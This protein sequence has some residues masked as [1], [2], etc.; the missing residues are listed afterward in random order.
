MKQLIVITL[1][2]V[3]SCAFSDSGGIAVLNP[4]FE[5]DT[6]SDRVPDNWEL[7]IGGNAKGKVELDSDQYHSG[8]KSVRISNASGSAPFVYTAIKS[9]QIAVQPSTTYVARFFAKATDA[10]KVSVHIRCEGAGNRIMYIEEGDYDWKEFR[11]QFT[12]AERTQLMRIFFVSEDVTG[13]LWIDDVSIELADVQ[14]ANL[15]EKHYPKDFPGV[16][17]RSRGPL[18]EHLTVF[19][20]RRQANDDAMEMALAALQGLVNR[21]SP[22]LYMINQTN[23]ENYDEM[24]LKYMQEKGYTGKEQRVSEPAELLKQFRKEISGAIVYDTNLPGS[25]HAACMLGGIKRAIPLS[26]ALLRKFDLPIVMDLRGKWKRNV[27]AYRFVYENYFDQMNHHVI[28]WFHPLMNTPYVV[29]YLVEFKIFTFW[30]SSYKDREKGADPAAEEKF[31]N[32]LLASTP[33]N[34]PVLGWPGYGDN[35]GIQEYNGVRWLSE[36]GKFMPGSGF[37]SNLSV[38]S[39]INPPDK[40]FT[41]KG[42]KREDLLELQKDKIYV[43]INVI[44]SGDALWYWQLWQ[45]NIWADSERGSVPIGW[46]MNG[47]LYETLPLVLQWYYEN[48][49]PNDLFFGLWYMNTASYA[50]RFLPKQKQQ[51]WK[52]WVQLTNEYCQKL[53]LEGIEL[54]N[55]SWGEPTPPTPET[56]RYYTEG[57]DNLKFILAD[58]GRHDSINPANA[59]YI[60][61]DTVVFHTLTRY[62]IWATSDEVLTR[63][64]EESVAWVVD[65]IKA[66]SPATRPGFMT[67]MAISW[68]FYP[69]WIKDIAEQLPDEYVVVNPYQLAK[70]YKDH[71]KRLAENTEKK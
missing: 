67:A 15:K 45:R 29:D 61:D 37:C 1:L 31:I 62:K 2:L 70:L 7:E 38:H 47:G 5:V 21:T 23:P 58:L 3:T 43:S 48:A 11:C 16:F 13:G 40:I 33:A 8:K 32:E 34:I 57:M 28:A 35:K 18:P 55:G 14:M 53:D 17:P 71:N 10:R 44:D 64:R 50:S 22:R 49:T 69:S 26:P 36:F 66:N 52:Q 4:G 46:C 12:T 54:Y 65:E 41:Q 59:N 51:I 68:Y 25:I 6:D 27:D 20:C 19:D 42:R 39:A 24:W 56:F 63:K 30:M 60:L 9:K